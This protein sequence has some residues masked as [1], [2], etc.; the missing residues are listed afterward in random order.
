VANTPT[1]L[2]VEMP[3]F[4]VRTHSP[5]QDTAVSGTSP[6]RGNFGAFWGYFCAMIADFRG[7]KSAHIAPCI[8]L[9]FS[10]L[11]VPSVREFSSCWAGWPP[12]YAGTGPA[13]WRRRI[14][15]APGV[16]AGEAFVPLGAPWTGG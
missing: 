5:A 1:V 2:S 14:L 8:P 12:S 10:R 6:D 11:W 9:C 3:L 16:A 4:V 7:V 15:L 13:S